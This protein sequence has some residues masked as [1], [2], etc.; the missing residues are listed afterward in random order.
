MLFSILQIKTK[1]TFLINQ[2]LTCPKPTAQMGWLPLLIL[3]IMFYLYS[4]DLAGLRS[5]SQYSTN[6]LHYRRMRKYFASN[7]SEEVAEK[8]CM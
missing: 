6:A 2:A 1:K 4:I 8:E 7:S 5:F 3:H